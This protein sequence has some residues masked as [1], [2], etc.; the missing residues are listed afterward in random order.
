MAFFDKLQQVAKS[1]ASEAGDM[2]ETTKLNAKISE[3][4]KKIAQFKTQMGEYFWAEYQSG[5]TLP[6]QAVDYCRQIVSCQAQID[7]LEAQIAEIKSSGARP[8][9]AQPIPE[10]R[11]MA[12]PQPMP[13]ASF[14]ANCGAELSPEARFCTN[15]GQPK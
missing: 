14:C 12:E 3:E 2:L 15:C 13:A 1:A 8:A 9:A 11:P 10:A 7:L 6:E 4:K 5:M